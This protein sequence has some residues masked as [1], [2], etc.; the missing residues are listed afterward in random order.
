M[1]IKKLLST[2]VAIA[3][4]TCMGTTAFAMDKS[5]GEIESNIEVINLSDNISIQTI[6]EIASSVESSLIYDDGTVVP[7]DAIVTIEDISITNYHSSEVSLQN[8]Y[9]VT[10]D[11]SISE[12][13]ET[14][15]SRKID[16]DSDDKNGSVVASATLEL[17]WTDGPG[18]DNVIDKVS[19]NL[20]VE[21]GRV[22][23]GEVR[24]GD[25]WRTIAFWTKKDVGSASSF[26]YRPS[27]TVPDPSAVY[28]VDF[29]NETF[30][31]SLRVS[32]NVLQ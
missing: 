19:G 22:S 3:M 28:Y 11:T 10:L 23:D 30:G 4:V 18:L 16:S 25:G 31:L 12:Q 27:I 15:N 14:P 7:V 29:E 20:T 2:A 24:Y 9:K 17:I 32:A 8:S 21:K 1:K 13:T 26:S 6:Q 5:L